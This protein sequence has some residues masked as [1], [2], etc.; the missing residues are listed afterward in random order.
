MHRGLTMDPSEKLERHEKLFKIVTTQTSH[1]WGATL[2]KMLLERTGSQDL[3]RMT[4]FIP[5]E[6]LEGRY[7][8]AK[9]RLFLFD[10]DVRFSYLF[11]FFS[12]FCSS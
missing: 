10:Y 7:H 9:K 8:K 6:Q 5:K 3:A 12:F 4:P 11:L 1:T 2:V